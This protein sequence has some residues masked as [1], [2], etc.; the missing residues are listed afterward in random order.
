M[1]KNTSRDVKDV[2]NAKPPTLTVASSSI[3]L[4]R[5]IKTL[6]KR[7]VVGVEGG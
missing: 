5:V 1:L 4:D 7:A 2:V 3:G 6:W